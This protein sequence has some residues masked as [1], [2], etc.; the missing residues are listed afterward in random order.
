MIKFVGVIIAATAL[1]G[2][3]G[4]EIT[5]TTFL[6]TGAAI[7]GIGTGTVLLA[8]GAFFDAQD[9]RRKKEIFDTML[10]R[11]QREVEIG[12]SVEN[13][14]FSLIADDIAQIREG[15][16]PEHRLIPRHAI[17]RDIILLGY[18]RDFKALTANMQKL[19]KEDFEQ[20]INSIKR[21]GP[22]E[23]D[24]VLASRKAS[25]NDLSELES[26]VRAANPLYKMVDPLFVRS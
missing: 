2:F 5:E 10:R 8:L 9:R 26:A 7:G 18:E 6:L 15:K 11:K 13:A 22:A 3:I 24:S 1:G 17:K 20:Q 4:G 25:H 12:L 16:V 23:L 14:L 21:L 19:N